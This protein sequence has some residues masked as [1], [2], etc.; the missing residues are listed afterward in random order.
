MFDRLR[1]SDRASERD[2][3][4]ILLESMIAISLI[5][6][7]MAALGVLFI[8]SMANTS[9]ER[10]RAGA[11]RVATT[12]LDDLNSRD[13]TSLVSG[14]T[15]TCV[16][17]TPS[18]AVTTYLASMTDAR[19]TDST[20]TTCAPTVSVS[21]VTRVIG[22]TTYTVNQ[23]LGW[24]SYTTAADG[25]ATC[26]KAG[27]CPATGGT[28]CYLRAVV[29]VSWNGS[30]CTPTSCTLV[31]STLISANTDP[32][33]KM[34]Q[35]LPAVPVITNPGAQSNAV[36]DTVSLQLAVNANTGVP[37][38]TW[39]ATGL[40]PGLAMNTAGLVSNTGQSL[41]ANGTPSTVTVTVTD[42]F[43]RQAT[44]T[45]T[46]RIYPQLVPTT[47]GPQ[48]NVTTDAV[49]LALKATGGQGVPYTW[50]LNSGSLPPGLTVNSTSNGDGSITGT[51][52]TPGQYAFT[53][54][55]TD[56][57]TTRTA[58][59]GTITWTVSYPPIAASNPGTQID[60]VGTA[61]TLQLS[62]SGG[63]GNFVWSNPDGSL[64]QTGL[65]ISPGG[66]IS[67][68]LTSTVRDVTV[69]LTVNDPTAGYSANVTFLW[70]VVGPP[71]ISG[72]GTQAMTETATESVALAYTCPNPSCTIVL[73]NTVPGLGLDTSS[74]R[75]TAN[76]TTSLTVSSGSGTVWLTGVVSTSAVTTGNSKTYTPSVKI[77]DSDGVPA[78]PAAGSWTVNVVPSVAIAPTASAPA[79]VVLTPNKPISGAAASASLGSPGYTYAFSGTKPSWLSINASTGALSGT[80]TPPTPN[81]AISFT[82]VATDSDGVQATATATWYVDDLTYSPP[83]SR[84]FPRGTPVSTSYTS[85]SAGG[86]GGNTYSATGLPAGLTM[87][88]TGTLSGTPSTKATYTVTIYVSDS[89]GATVAATQTMTVT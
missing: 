71:T 27:S 5:T 85:Y 38:L 61:R 59:T 32:T 4:F 72:T 20:N 16:Y 49:N 83:A 82:I 39:A 15:S 3:G 17:P 79:D 74:S 76:S 53:L 64:A 67:G 77:T 30:N 33:F 68:T 78:T 6:V 26:V 28:G 10:T 23:Y 29:A 86:T 11:A 13:A 89:I 31:T 43:L 73:T 34:N 65:T 52:T 9:H 81:A 47:P 60:T 50:S 21:P 2:D 18:T 88:S 25:T 45:F 24:C 8:S 70:R 87:S 14:R 7:I 1:R 51:P 40:P 48:A 41:V 62:A 57:S 37:P 66:K 63:S 80:A 58:T 12:V 84:S 56:A 19:D 36:G 46:W 42:A 69:N 54:K 44:A 75:S 35:P 22:S 55:V